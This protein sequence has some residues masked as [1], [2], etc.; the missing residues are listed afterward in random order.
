LAGAL[1]KTPLGELTVLPRPSSWIKGDLLPRKRE[2]YREGEG[3]GWVIGRREGRSEGKKKRGR[4]GEG[5]GEGK[6]GGGK[7]I[8][9]IPILVCFRRR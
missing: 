9:A 1:P 6:K 7:G 4:G 2:G 8:L 3:R 5:K